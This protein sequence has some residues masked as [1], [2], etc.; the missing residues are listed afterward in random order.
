MT[1]SNSILHFPH[2][3]L[4][5][6]VYVLFAWVF[7][8]RLITIHNAVIWI[9]TIEWKIITLIRWTG[10][11]LSSHH[12]HFSLP[13]FIRYDLHNVDVE[14]QRA[15]ERVYSCAE[16]KIIINLNTIFSRSVTKYMKF[17][18]CNHW[19]DMAVK[20]NG[21]ISTYLWTNREKKQKR[22]M[23]RWNRNCQTYAASNSKCE[24]CKSTSIEW[25][26]KWVICLPNVMCISIYTNKRN[27]YSTCSCCMLNKLH[28]KWS[29]AVCCFFISFSEFKSNRI[30]GWHSP[31]Q[32][33]LKQ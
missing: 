19:N 24:S 20:V 8:C 10:H 14:G 33:M 26:Q 1:Q 27:V 15:S 11:R 23:K 3:S 21:N 32:W 28:M 22:K 6:C 31:Q 25:M 4:E 12:H 29:C 17:H 13:F 2:H 7:V 18:C 9:S 16:E 30:S 5:F